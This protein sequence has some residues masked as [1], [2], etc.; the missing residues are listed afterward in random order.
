L[1][2]VSEIEPN[3]VI[4]YAVR[5]NEQSWLTTSFIAKSTKASIQSTPRLDAAMLIAE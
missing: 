4:T 2:N 1:V 3:I 5:D